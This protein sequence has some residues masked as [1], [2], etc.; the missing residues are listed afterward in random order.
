M[1]TL[2]IIVAPIAIV[3]ADIIIYIVVGRLGTRSFGK[4]VKYEPFTGGEEDIPTRGLY[5]S[6]LF[7]FAMLFMIVEAFALL[8]AGSYAATSNFYPLLFLAGGSGVI[9]LTVWWFLIVG[10]GKF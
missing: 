7:V 10:G 3:I 5:R 2:D 9:M 1:A 6:E 4:G 8:L